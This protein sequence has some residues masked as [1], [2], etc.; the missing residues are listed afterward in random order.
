[1]LFSICYL[2]LS[3][4]SVYQ[5]T[6]IDANE[7]KSRN[8]I[9]LLRF[10]FTFVRFRSFERIN[11]ISSSLDFGILIIFEEKKRFFIWWIY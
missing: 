10:K 2:I 7:T 5:P 6:R 3:I 4:A 8:A 9:I 1:M 11:N